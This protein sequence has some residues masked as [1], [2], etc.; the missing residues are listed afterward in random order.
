VSRVAVVGLGYV[1]LTT[2]VGLGQLGHDIVGIDIDESK[3]RS[4]SDGISPIFE[5]G[6]DEAL[7]TLLIQKKISF[8]SRIEE[9]KGAN[10]EFIFLCVATPQDQTGSA[11][12]STLFSVANQLAGLAP[13][14]SVLVIKSTVPVGTG[15]KLSKQI[16][17]KEIF[18]ASNPEFL[19]EGTALKDFTE[20]DRVVVGA[21]EA[22][23]AERVL[24]LYQ[25][26]HSTKLSTNLQSAELIKY[27]SNA[28]LAMRL[29]FTNDMANFTEKVNANVDDVL[30][31]LGLDSRIGSSFLKP[32]PGWGGSCFPK[33]TRALLAMASQ[34]GVSLPLVQSSLSSNQEAML[35]VVDKI[36]ELA[37]GHLA[38]KTV[39]IWGLA[40]KANTDD[41][42]DSPSVFIINT[43]LQRGARVQAYDPAAIAPEQSG[44]TFFD[45]GV[46]AAR[47][48]DVLAVLTEWQE[49]ADLSPDE[50]TDVM[51]SSVVFDARRI[52]PE[53]WKSKATVF[54]VIGER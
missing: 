52:L 30:L 51:K 37:G 24:E 45:S 19:R 7:A 49:F 34:H 48:A 10:P 54:N 2:A 14:D 22:D 43:L 50:V 18:I 9:V 31:G 42:R 47:G 20:P 36:E 6:M 11:D 13:K 15:S 53:S 29:S 16:K 23:V 12:L 46:A 33:D 41:V 5:A 21:N 38:N 8:T 4:L 39:A 27:A 25:G 3:V 26:L 40:F 1:G 28:Y 35:R 32:G 17:E 44:L